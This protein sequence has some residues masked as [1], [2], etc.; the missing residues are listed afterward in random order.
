M[1]IL[2]F[3]SELL[4]LNV[5]VIALM[6][7]IMVLFR[8]H[9]ILRDDMQIAGDKL[10]VYIAIICILNKILIVIYLL[11]TKG[12][13]IPEVI[14]LTVLLYIEFNF[15]VQHNEWYNRMKCILILTIIT[16]IF[17]KGIN[18]DLSV[19]LPKF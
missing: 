17:V 13:I 18:I 16:L 6:G 19:K 11:I 1:G 8:Y 15:K 2:R 9:N 3:M 10:S 7:S 14:Y 5:K 4:V 12:K